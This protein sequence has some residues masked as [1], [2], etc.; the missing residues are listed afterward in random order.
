MKK[1]LL[2]LAIVL[3]GVGVMAQTTYPKVT[4]ESELN[5]GDKVLLVGFNDDGSAYAMSYQKSNNRHAVAINE[6]GGIIVTTVA[7]VASSQTEPFE[8]TVGGSTG[9]CQRNH[10]AR[11]TQ[12]TKRPT[13]DEIQRR[14]KTVLLQRGDGS[15]R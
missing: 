4:S 9:A 7:T 11:R 12:K 13:L 10:G 6:N 5:V 8:L 15:G 2:F 1:L 14:G 3:M